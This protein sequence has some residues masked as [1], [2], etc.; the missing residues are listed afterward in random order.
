MTDTLY[1]IGFTKKSATEFFKT[2]ELAE[3]RTVVD[4]R[5][6]DTSQLAGFTKKDDLAFFLREVSGI[7]YIHELN[8][9]PTQELV[10]SY[11]GKQIGA[12]EFSAQYLELLRS[13]G[14][15]D[16]LDE[17]DYRANTVLL[18]S[19]PDAAYCHRRIAAGYLQSFWG[20]FE[21]VHL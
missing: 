10:K 2:L 12:D 9:A 6:N 1:T 3:V 13:R 19:E 11:R 15:H 16:R 21:I 5:I 20:D 18:C 7:R 4:V 8:L 14:G 17:S